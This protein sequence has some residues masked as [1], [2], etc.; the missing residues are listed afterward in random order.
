MYVANHWLALGMQKNLL[1]WFFGMYKI[2]PLN[3]ILL[4]YLY[5]SHKKP[6]REHSYHAYLNTVPKPAKKVLEEASIGCVISSKDLLT[7][8]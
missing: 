7:S 4:C 3:A 8:N 6:E 5:M 2:L 1:S